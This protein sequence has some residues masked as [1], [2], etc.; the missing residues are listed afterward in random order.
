MKKQ[1]SLRVSALLTLLSMLVVLAVLS[2]ATYAWFT[3]SVNTNVEPMEGSVSKGDVNLAIAA[4]EGGTYDK[5]SAVSLL[6]QCDT[7]LPLSTADLKTFYSATARTPE[8]KACL[9]AQVPEEKA[10][11]ELVHG[12]VY[13]KAQYTDADLY[14]QQQNLKFEGSAQLLA[15]LRLGMTITSSG[16]EKTYFF[17][18]DDLAGTGGAK[19]EDTTLG[20]AQSVVSAVSASGAATFAAD[21][22]ESMATYCAQDTG[23]DDADPEPGE[24]AL[25]RLKQDSPARVE[26]WLYMEGCDE[27]CLNE[28]Q[29]NELGFNLAF[30][31]VKVEAGQ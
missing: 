8:G 11:T 4:S 12:E 27:N 26:L 23:G 22:A 21:P 31:G 2:T 5:K 13:V 1:L 28:A 16:E 30:A 20:G 15:S 24:K 3:L 10:E 25:C 19:A 7:L 29:A 18:L 14:F 6:S 17:K 9:Y